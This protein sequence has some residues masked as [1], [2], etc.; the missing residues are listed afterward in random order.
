MSNTYLRNAIEITLK[1]EIEAFFLLNAIG[2]AA[3][4]QKIKNG[5]TKSTQVIPC[6]CGLN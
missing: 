5:K 6:I 3:P 1:S 2:T 4:I